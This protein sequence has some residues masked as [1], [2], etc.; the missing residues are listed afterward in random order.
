MSLSTVEVQM[1]EGKRRRRQERM[2]WLDS[3]T[4]SMDMNLSKLWEI[5]E[6]RETWCAAVHGVTKSWTWL[7][8]WTTTIKM[9]KKK[10]PTKR[11]LVF[12]SN[13]IL[14]N[15]DILI[16]VTRKK[17]IS[18]CQINLRNT[19]INS[20]LYRVA[21]QNPSYDPVCGGERFSIT[22]PK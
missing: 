6:G 22:F 14:W 12:F 20:F 21:S 10:T 13:S 16:G 1:N 4:N 7:S 18:S 11:F 17:I 3:I 9:E 19:G 15:T 2:R 8:D 5:V